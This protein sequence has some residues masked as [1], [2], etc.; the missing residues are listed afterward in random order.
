MTSYAA[1][2]AD[3]VNSKKYQTAERN[4]LQEAIIDTVETLNRSFRSVLIKP[5]DF[6]SGDEVQGLF[7]EGVYAYLYFRLL[8]I[9]LLPR[10]NSR[11]HRL[12]CLAHTD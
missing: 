12:W 7:C 11:R 1:L 10:K 9:N 8:E 2:I 6:S 3:V 4:D 5:V